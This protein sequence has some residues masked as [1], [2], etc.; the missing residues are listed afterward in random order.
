M[1]T[2]IKRFKIPSRSQPDKLRTVVLDGDGFRC[3][4]PAVKHPCWH[5]RKVQ[6]Y[7]GEIEGEPEKCWYSGQ[8]TWL[9]EHHLLR[10]AL[11]SQSLTVYL[12][13]WVHELAT[14]SKE[15]EEHL[16][17]LYFNSEE[18]MEIK[19]KAKV[20]EV[21]IRNLVSGD[22]GFQI[23]L[24]SE[25]VE[26][27]MKLAQL[28]PEKLLKISQPRYLIANDSLAPGATLYASVISVKKSNLKRGENYAE[29]LLSAAPAEA[30][31]VAKLGFLP[32]DAE[33]EVSYRQI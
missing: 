31:G 2:T 19:F 17:Q 11:R 22:K 20:K 21:S 9:E 18:P 24:W 16:P 10:A 8:R 5:V 3:D 13:H 28:G 27:V 25:N 29:I 4:C 12:T 15:F 23:E 30:V 7:L 32:V 33:V 1:I 6:K 14:R 26:E